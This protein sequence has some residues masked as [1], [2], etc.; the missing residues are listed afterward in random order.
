MLHIFWLVSQGREIQVNYSSK[1]SHLK[2][3][4]FISGYPVAIGSHNLFARAPAGAHPQ[5]EG[6]RH[7]S[8]LSFTGRDV[9]SWSLSP[10]TASPIAFSVF[11]ER[12]S[13]VLHPTRHPA[14]PPLLHTI[15]KEV[16]SSV[17]TGCAWFPP[18]L[19]LHSCCSI[20]FLLSLHPAAKH[21]LEAKHSN[22]VRLSLVQQHLLCQHKKPQGIHK[23]HLQ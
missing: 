22:Y 11:P 18:V 4:V 3:P 15:P 12:N 7:R 14:P 5:T 23:E 1:P 9:C 13:S 16:A 19:S 8:G 6:S 10:F 2:R 21:C 17:L 20:S